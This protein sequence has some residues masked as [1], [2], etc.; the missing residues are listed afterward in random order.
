MKPKIIEDTPL[1]NEKAKY[2]HVYNL[3][4]NDKPK[5]AIKEFKLFISMFPNSSLSDDA[6]RMIGTAYANLKQYNNAILEYK[7]VIE[8]YPNSS[9]AAI[10]L[11]DIAYTYFYSL[12]D[13]PNVHLYYSKFIEE[14]NEGDE[15][16][17]EIAINQLDNWSEETKRYEGY[18]QKQEQS[19][20]LSN[21]SSYKEPTEDDK[22]FAWTA[23]LQVMKERLKAPSTAKFPFSYYGQDI[24]Q[25]V[26]GKCGKGCKNRTP[27]GRICSVNWKNSCILR[28]L[29]SPLGVN[30]GPTIVG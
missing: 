12:N 20:E 29:Y 22:A 25:K 24:K 27:G 6:Q 14:A 19:N 13:F 11:Y 9:S 26:Q 21:E 10:T 7:K 8:K 3:W 23:A 2:D 4:Y 15:K 18:A 5:E 30:L 17:K 28:N 16:W 1:E